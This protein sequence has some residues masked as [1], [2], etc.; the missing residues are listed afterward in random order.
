M[1][2]KELRAQNNAR[3]I[4]AN[5][6]GRTAAQ[7]ARATAEDR[8]EWA[9]LVNQALVEDSHFN[10]PKDAYRR[11]NYVDSIPQIL[12]GYSRGHSFAVKELEMS[13]WSAEKPAIA[14]RLSVPEGTRMYMTLQ[15]DQLQ[16]FW[17]RNVCHA[18]QDPGSDAKRIL[19]YTTVEAY[20]ILEIPVPDQ[21]A[22]ENNNYKLQ[23]LRTTGRSNWRKG[24][25]RRDAVWGSNR[26]LYKLVHLTLL[27]WLGNLILHGPEGMS[28]VQAFSS[29]GGETI[30]WLRVVEEAV[31]LIQVEP[32]RIWMG[33]K[34]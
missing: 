27:D 20:N 6:N 31:N 26:E 12:K 14:E 11:S 2:S 1:V 32:D 19:L 22:D 28:S 33:Q 9:Y 16:D 3:N 10:F 4:E 17:E 21:D 23:H 18:A 29:G 5:L 24:G 7:K 13:A 34:S 8:E 15:E 25:P 30:V